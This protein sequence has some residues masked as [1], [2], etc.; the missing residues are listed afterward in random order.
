[1]KSHSKA[2]S[3]TTEYLWSQIEPATAIACAC[4]VTYRPLF[5]DMKVG[6]STLFST[7]TRSR[8]TPGSDQGGD[9]NSAENGRAEALSVPKCQGQ[10][11]SR[12]RDLNDKAVQGKLHIIEISVPRSH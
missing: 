7:H 3:F 8:N 5:R 2:D 10:N 12:L 11:G 9:L 6:L 4:L 1:M